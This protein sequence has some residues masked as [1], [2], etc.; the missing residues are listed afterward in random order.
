MDHTDI[1]SCIEYLGDN[2][3]ASGSFDRKIV[4]WSLSPLLSLDKIPSE[5]SLEYSIMIEQRKQSIGIF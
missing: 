2:V 5:D 3:V 1:V 4:L